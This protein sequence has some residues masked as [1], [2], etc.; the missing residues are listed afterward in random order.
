M[1]TQPQ[2]TPE[3]VRRV[4]HLARLRLTDDEVERLTG[5]L[6][7]LL[8]HFTRLQAVN[9][10]N[11]PPTSHVL[12]LSN[13]FRDDEPR[14]GLPVEEALANAPAADGPFFEVP[15]IVDTE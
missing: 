2:L 1:S 14:P 12:E 10:E 11:I 8:A 13:V 9:T 7:T 6:N 3:A 5:Q 4:G 15:R